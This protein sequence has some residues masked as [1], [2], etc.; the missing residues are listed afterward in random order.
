MNERVRSDPTSVPILIGA[1]PRPSIVDPL[2]D[3]LKTGPLYNTVHLWS[4]VRIWASQVPSVPDEQW[5]LPWTIPGFFSD[6]HPL[7][8]QKVTL[9][10]GLY[11]RSKPLGALE[12]FGLSRFYDMENPYRDCAP[13]A[14]RGTGTDPNRH[15]RSWRPETRLPVRH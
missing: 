12:T 5:G 8:K 2:L 14:L 7:Q 11:I 4:R 10:N 9:R 15:S 3:V 6:F 13:I 1:D